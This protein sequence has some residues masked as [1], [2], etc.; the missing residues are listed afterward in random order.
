MNYYSSV[1]GGGPI[2]LGK[3][4]VIDDDMDSLGSLLGM[5]KTYARWVNITA[6]YM[7]GCSV[8]LGLSL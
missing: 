5:N 6:Q 4:P 2:P 8:P 3:I 1:L 7:G